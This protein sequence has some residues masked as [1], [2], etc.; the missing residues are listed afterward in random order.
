[1]E[2]RGKSIPPTSTFFRV[3]SLEN[4]IIKG[5]LKE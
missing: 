1:M 4:E 3:A 2:R 5:R